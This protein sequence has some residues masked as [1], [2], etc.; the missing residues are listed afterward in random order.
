MSEECAPPCDCERRYNKINKLFAAAVERERKRTR[1]CQQ[2]VH[3][4]IQRRDEAHKREMERAVARARAECKQLYAAQINA[5][6]T[7]LRHTTDEDLLNMAANIDHYEE[8]LPYRGRA[9]TLPAALPPRP[10]E[11]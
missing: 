5:L 10:L 7:Q 3:T 2:A 1:E 8:E 4:F 9:R 11:D 6:Q